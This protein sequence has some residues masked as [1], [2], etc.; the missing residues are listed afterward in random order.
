MDAISLLIGL[1]VGAGLGALIGYLYARSHVAGQAA[2]AEHFQ[3]MAGDALDQS[4]RRFLEMAAGRLE[5]VN[6]RAA[7]ELDTR[8]NAVEHR[9]GSSRLPRSPSR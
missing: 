4:T 3:A 8:K 7:G 9:P 2:A 6:A 1:L 5:A